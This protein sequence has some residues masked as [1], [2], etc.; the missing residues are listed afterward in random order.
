MLHT[1]NW[2]TFKYSTQKCLLYRQTI[3]SLSVPHTTHSI[4]TLDLYGLINFCDSVKRN[5][6]DKFSQLTDIVTT[7][8]MQVSNCNVYCPYPPHNTVLDTWS[9]ILRTATSTN[10]RRCQNSSSSIKQQLAYQHQQ[11]ATEKNNNYYFISIAVKPL[12]RTAS[13]HHIYR[14]SV[15]RRPEQPVTNNKV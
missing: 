2:E 1:V 7:T 11:H 5:N 13:T 6:T 10:L 3:A 15:A 12:R 8:N 9:S 4:S 14:T